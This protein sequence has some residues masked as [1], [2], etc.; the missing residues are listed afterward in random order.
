MPVPKA[1]EAAVAALFSAINTQDVGATLR[2][3]DPQGPLA[4]AFDLWGFPALALYVSWGEAVRWQ[5]VSGDGEAVAVR[6]GVQGH[7]VQLALRERDRGWQVYAAEPRADE[8]SILNPA[9]ALAE[10]GGM[11][12]PWLAPPPDEVEALLRERGTDRL[13]GPSALVS[14]IL[15]WRLAQR[16][17]ELPP[18]PPRAWAAAME[19]QAT[20]QGD[21]SRATELALHCYGADKRELER[22][23]FLLQAGWRLHT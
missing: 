4:C 13:L 8:A 21:G 18:L 10:A 17:L 12:E 23:M 15:L 1:A 19:Y 22:A 20:R 7:G 14:R 11:H 16:F 6:W 3:L 5:E 2:L 9:F